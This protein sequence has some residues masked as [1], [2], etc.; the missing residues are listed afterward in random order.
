MSG[1]SSCYVV[2][3]NLTQ[4]GSVVYLRADET[5]A[6][7]LAEAHPLPTEEEAEERLARVRVHEEIVTEPYVFEAELS[8]GAIRPKSAREILRSAG[9]S[10]RLRRPDR[11]AA[12][13]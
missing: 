2:T 6:T 8:D 13:A 9:P 3:G 11:G 10:T 4:A 12:T 5:W 7:S 1:I